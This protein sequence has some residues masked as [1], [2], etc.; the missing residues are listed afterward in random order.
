M[1]HNNTSDFVDVWCERN[2]VTE[3]DWNSI[4]LHAEEDNAS[5]E[6][7]NN[8]G[9]KLNF[10]TCLFNTNLL[11]KRSQSS[12]EN[13]EKIEELLDNCLCLSVC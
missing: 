13:A 12:R 6:S 7:D 1:F 5:G 2:N 9:S 11:L 4:I 3:T 8:E 10:A